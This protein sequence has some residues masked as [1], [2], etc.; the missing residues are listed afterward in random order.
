LSSANEEL[1]RLGLAAE[2]TVGHAL[3]A[4][5]EEAVAPTLIQP[6]IVY[7]H[8][9]EIS[10]LAKAMP[11]DERFVE[12]FE[13]YIAGTE[14]GDNWSELNDPVE[15]NQRFVDDQHRRATEDDEEAHP[16]DF[17]FIEAVEYGM[18]PT[19]GIGPGI[20]RLAMLLTEADS[21]SDVM[22]FPLLRPVASQSPHYEDDLWDAAV[23]EDPREQAGPR[24]G[25]LDGP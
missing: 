11:D 13:L 1:R 8:P 23:A 16:L 19:T 15:L 25:P 2:A 12:R 18:P 4:L 7:G 10:P 14:Q 6:T 22:F 3:V 24:Q 20:E 9:V 17:E 5:F 21:I